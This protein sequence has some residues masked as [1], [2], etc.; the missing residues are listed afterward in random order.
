LRVVHSNRIGDSLDRALIR[1]GRQ[2]IT[3]H[4]AVNAALTNTSSCP[5]FQQANILDFQDNH[6][7]RGAFGCCGTILLRSRSKRRTSR[8][9]SR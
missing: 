6:R 1:H 7:R 8:Y 5:T 3:S 2:S 4:R 9:A